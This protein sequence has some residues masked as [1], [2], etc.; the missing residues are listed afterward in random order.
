L[1]D[2]SKALCLLFWWIS[3]PFLAFNRVGM[4]KTHLDAL[5]RRTLA[6]RH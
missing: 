4:K 2:A 6:D 5:N 1:A 3:R